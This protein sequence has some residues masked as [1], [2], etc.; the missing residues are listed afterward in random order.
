M[1]YGELSFDQDIEKVDLLPDFFSFFHR[2]SGLFSKLEQFV[3]MW[4]C[5]VD[6]VEHIFH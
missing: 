4:M 5:N 2:F 6:V 3:L 1:F